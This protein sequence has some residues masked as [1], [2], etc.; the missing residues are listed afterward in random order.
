MSDLAQHIA[1]REQRHRDVLEAARLRRVARTYLHRDM[2][3]GYILLVLAAHGFAR[4]DIKRLYPFY[5]RD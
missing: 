3:D 4:E 5:R 1:E 2:P